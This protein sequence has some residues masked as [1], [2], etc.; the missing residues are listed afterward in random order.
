M[1][2]GQLAFVVLSTGVTYIRRLVWC[3]TIPGTEK[4]TVIN[5]VFIA[6]TTNAF[7]FHVSTHMMFLTVSIV[8]TTFAFATKTVRCIIGAV[9]LYFFGNSR[10][11]LVQC[12]CDAGKRVSL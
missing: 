4:D 11:V 1:I 10:R 9:P 7:A 12:F 3:I 8:N 6:L 5:R 2:L